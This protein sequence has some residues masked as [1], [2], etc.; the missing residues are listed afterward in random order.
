MKLEGWQI[1]GSFTNCTVGTQHNTVSVD[2]L[3]PQQPKVSG[4]CLARGSSSQLRPPP[5][6][7][8]KV[9]AVAAVHLLVPI[10][11]HI[12]ANWGSRPLVCC[13]HRRWLASIVFNALQN[14][15][16]SMTSGCRSWIM[17]TGHWF[18]VNFSN[19][20]LAT[21]PRNGRTGRCSGVEE[22]VFDDIGHA[23][24]KA[25]NSNCHPVDSTALT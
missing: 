25:A 24:G 15:H 8:L 17:T 16:N 19:I 9:A 23:E 7:E 10:P 13:R 20:R 14:Q 5:R 3:L 1:G 12:C 4:T 2:D 18:P 22:E 6:P 21:G 11:C